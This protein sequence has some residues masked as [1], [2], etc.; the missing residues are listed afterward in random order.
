M[1]QLIFSQHIKQHR[2]SQISMWM[3]RAVDSHAYQQK[4][5]ANIPKISDI[6]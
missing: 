1:L 5:S 3:K 6:S 4:Q 2:L